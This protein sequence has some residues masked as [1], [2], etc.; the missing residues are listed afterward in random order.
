MYSYSSTQRAQRALGPFIYPSLS[1]YLRQG[2]SLNGEA[3]RS[4]RLANRLLGSTSLW[5]PIILV[6]LLLLL[7]TTVLAIAGAH[8]L[9]NQRA[10][11]VIPLP[12][13]LLRST[14]VSVLTKGFISPSSLGSHQYFLFL[15]CQL[16]L[17]R[18]KEVTSTPTVHRNKIRQ[19]IT[20]KS[21]VWD[22]TVG[23]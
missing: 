15:F 3:H 21:L 1:Y 16:Y 23:W 14:L 22:I 8:L 9:A 2:H 11:G 6:L 7:L 18:I 12:P 19:K 10:P 4:A 5:L 20:H 13:F 17:P